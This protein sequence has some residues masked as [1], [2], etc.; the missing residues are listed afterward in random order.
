MRTL[1]KTDPS[2]AF[3]F[4]FSENAPAVLWRIVSVPA[5]SPSDLA[6][7]KWFSDECEARA[8]A[9]AI[10]ESRGKLL[11]YDRYHRAE[12]QADRVNAD[13]RMST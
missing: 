8:H 10:R 5:G 6:H 9:D 3:E 4:A 2:I 13:N 12:A 11:A 7:A 1:I